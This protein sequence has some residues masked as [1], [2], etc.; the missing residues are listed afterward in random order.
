MGTKPPDIMKVIFGYKN[1]F[2]GE[3]QIAYGGS[4]AHR[5]AK[6]AAQILLERIKILSLEIDGLRLDFVGVGALW[7]KIISSSCLPKEIILR[8]AARSNSE[9]DVKKLCNEVAALYTNGP[10][11]GGGVRK[12]IE[13]SIAIT[14][15]YIPRNIVT[16]ETRILG[17][18]ND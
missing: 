8:V 15:S 14:S 11:G 10:A 7:P 12:Y 13:E 1:G 5:R 16:C 17:D 2:F 6:L 3:A 4:G 18:E 9:N